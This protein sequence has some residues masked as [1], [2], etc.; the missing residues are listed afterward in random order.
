MN[1][2]SARIFVSDLLVVPYVYISKTMQVC[3]ELV[4]THMHNFGLK[5]VI[6]SEERQ[7]D[8]K[9]KIDNQNLSL[10]NVI[11]IHLNSCEV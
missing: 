11:K 4:L 10:P 9:K 3:M 1:K 8:L 5:A 7:T 2:G 6:D